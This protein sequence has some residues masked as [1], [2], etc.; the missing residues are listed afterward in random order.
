[1]TRATLLLTTLLAGLSMSVATFANEG[2]SFSDIDKDG[3]QNVSQQELQDAGK[4]N[5]DVQQL[6]K[7]NDGVLSEE[8]YKKAKD[9]MKNK[10]QQ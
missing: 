3:D 4:T 9:M 6:D 5:V 1:M 7:D 2:K 10:R 8:E